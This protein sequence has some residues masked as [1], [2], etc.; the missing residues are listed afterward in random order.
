MTMNV[1][2]RLQLRFNLRNAHVSGRSNRNYFRRL[3]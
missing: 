3:F 1:L 2:K